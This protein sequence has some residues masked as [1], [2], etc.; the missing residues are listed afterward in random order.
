MMLIVLCICAQLEINSTVGSEIDSLEAKRYHLFTDIDGFRS[1]QFTESGDSI[2]VSLQYLEQGISKDSTVIIDHETAKSLGSYISNFRMIIEDDHFRETFV[3]TF[4]IG[5][6]MVS[7]G[8]IDLVAK[9]STGD[10][11]QNAACCMTGGC[12]LGAYGAALLTRDVRTEVD[13][14]GLPA[15]CLT[16]EGIGCFFIPIQIE[17]QYYSFSK[18]AYVTGAGVGSG[19]GYLWAKKQHR[20]SDVLCT[21]IGH[22]IVAFDNEGFPITEQEV[23]AANRGTNEALIGTLGIAGGLMGAGATLFA[24]LSPWVDKH[25][26]EEWQETAITAAAVVLSATELVILSKFFVSKGREIDRKATIDRL[27]YRKNL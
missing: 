20:S 13:T 16:G 9:S 1:A 8:D 25:A 18:A 12:A 3:Q 15:P 2:V 7:Q 11:I 10:L 14:I 6:P 19:L 27:K 24:L 26:E 21:A 4:R 22:G 23:A 17:R 5:W